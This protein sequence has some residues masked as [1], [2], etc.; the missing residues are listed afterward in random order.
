MIPKMAEASLCIVGSRTSRFVD[1]FFFLF[2]DLVVETC[3]TSFIF[4]LTRIDGFKSHFTFRT[5][6]ILWNEI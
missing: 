2:A 3:L 6:W 1:R 4:I 5:T